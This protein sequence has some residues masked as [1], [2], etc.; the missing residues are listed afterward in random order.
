[1]HS[2][3]VKIILLGTIF[4]GMLRP[5]LT[6][7]AAEQAEKPVVAAARIE[8]AD[9]ARE[10]SFEAELRPYQ[11]VELHAR[12]SGYLD[13][14]KVDAGDRVKEGQLLGTLDVPESKIEIEHALASERR[15]Q[16]E[17]KRA[18][19]AYEEAHLAWSRI[20]A[21]DQ[22]QPHL[23]ARQDIDAATA[24]DR[25]AEAALDAARE[26][27]NVANADVK[28]LRAM[29]EYTQIT[30]PF[31][32]IITKRYSDPGALIQAGTSTGSMPVVRVSQV[33]KLR[34]VIPVSLYFVSRIKVGDPVK[35]RIP[36]VDRTVTGAIARFSHKV[37][38]GTRTMEAEVDVP[39]ADL[40]LIPGIYATAVLQA[41]RRER[42]LVAP[43]EAV[44][45]DKS[46]GA[47]VYVINRDGV[48]E[49]RPVT[50][51]LETPSKL[52]IL[53]GVSQDELV[54]VGSRTQVK[55]GQIVEPKL[56]ATPP[57]Q[58]NV[59]HAAKAG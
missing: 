36:S 46:G 7:H 24:R 45:R 13:E 58:G 2:Q 44:N 26:Q 51:G 27:A 11:E 57:P 56:T 9:L 12:V 42:A 34:L 37:E 48:V 29:L 52:E 16:A 20:S 14:L 21:T 5:P 25:S 6:S 38:T 32:G 40:S 4:F 1:M 53:K 17:I 55:A 49:V 50:I 23:I 43:V 30:A 28:K 35:I 33:D 54:L 15:S 8:Y 31:A 41:D 47:N 39:N 18:T 3:R 22:A 10:V 59:V 19:A